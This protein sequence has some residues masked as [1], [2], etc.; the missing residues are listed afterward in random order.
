MRDLGIKTVRGKNAVAGPKRILPGQSRDGHGYRVKPVFGNRFQGSYI[1][2]TRYIQGSFLV[3]SPKNRFC[4]I[5]YCSINYF[6]KALPMFCAP[7]HID[8][9]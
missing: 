2:M 4:L 6:G 5:D 3:L 9:T 8:H 1:F 7:D